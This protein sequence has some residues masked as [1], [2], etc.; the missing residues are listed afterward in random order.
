[1]LYR[2]AQSGEI[3]GSAD[4]ILTFVSLEN[5]AMEFLLPAAVQRLGCF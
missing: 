3:G 5:V 2:L 4:K 1:M